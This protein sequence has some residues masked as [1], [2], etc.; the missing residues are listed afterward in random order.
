MSVETPAPQAGAG[1]AASSALCPACAKPVAAGAD[2][3]AH[4]GAVA[5]ERLRCVHCRALVDVD[6]APDVRF[7]CRICGGVRIPIDDAAVVRSPVQI[8]LLKKATVAR[9]ATT[10]WGIVA[11]VVAAFGV[12][13]VLVLA[14]VV[15]VADP[16][17]LA[18]V[19]AGVAAC[20]P[21]GFAA[22]A[23]RKSRVHRAELVHAVEA[24]WIAAAADIARARGGEIDSGT[25]AKLTR[26]SEATAAELLAHMSREGML[27]TPSMSEG[28]HPYK[29]VEA[30][31][32][33]RQVLAGGD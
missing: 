28:A 9:S 27:E 29:L 32:R 30:S 11:G 26:A 10:I 23:F 25:L 3:C 31:A 24:A 16:P 5:G 17:T 19:M 21:F 2:R 13:A 14:L 18:A 12:L 15:S 22:V 33:A 4:C 8:E 6:A 7:V 1:D 20:I